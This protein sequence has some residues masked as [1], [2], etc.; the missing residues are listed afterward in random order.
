MVFACPS[1]RWTVTY[2]M[3]VPGL[4]DRRTCFGDSWGPVRPWVRCCWRYVKHPS[5]LSLRPW[6]PPG[7][8][9]LRLVTSW[10]SLLLDQLGCGW[11]RGFL[12]SFAALV[13]RYC[14]EEGEGARAAGQGF[15]ALPA[16]C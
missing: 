2:V 11:C 16:L 15:E 9:W 6:G 7:E 12:A 14:M 4:G 3:G 1:E 8:C 5:P 10:T 13:A